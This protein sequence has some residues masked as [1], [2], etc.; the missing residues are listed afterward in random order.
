MLKEE[1]DHIKT[2]SYFADTKHTPTKIVKLEKPDEPLMIDKDHLTSNCDWQPLNWKEQIS[3]IIEMRK[4]RDAPVDTM[5]CD[6]ISDVLASP[7]VI[8]GSTLL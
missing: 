7:K 6:V 4:L 1:E 3:K 8:M 2:S 5:G